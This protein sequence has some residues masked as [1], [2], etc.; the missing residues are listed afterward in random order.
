MVSPSQFVTAYITE[1]VS[2]KP[3][4]FFLDPHSNLYTHGSFSG[5][6]GLTT[7]HHLE[8]HFSYCPQA[9]VLIKNLNTQTKWPAKRHSLKITKWTMVS[10]MD[11]S[12]ALC[13]RHLELLTFGSYDILPQ[14]N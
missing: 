10:Q 9:A 14:Y 12:L 2:A 7:R 6:M 11:L 3:C 8:F 13:L 4:S 5:G 1:A